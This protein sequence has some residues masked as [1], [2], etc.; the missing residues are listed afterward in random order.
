MFPSPVRLAVIFSKQVHQQL[1][2]LPLSPTVQIRPNTE[3]PD[4]RP[5]VDA[6]IGA[7]VATGAWDTS[8]DVGSTDG[9]NAQSV[10]VL[11]DAGLPRLAMQAQF[12]D[13]TAFGGQAT[14]GERAGGKCND[15]RAYETGPEEESTSQGRR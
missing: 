8:K 12:C 10:N 9:H 1:T 7:E 4:L 15:T 14:E 3:H 11:S 5:P 13:T 6:N 2:R